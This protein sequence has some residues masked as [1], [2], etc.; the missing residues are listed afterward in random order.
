[1]NIFISSKIMNIFMLLILLAAML[2]LASCGSGTASP[3]NEPHTSGNNDHLLEGDPEDF[4]KI[5][6]ASGAKVKKTTLSGESI[7][8]YSN[9][10]QGYVMM[11]NNGSQRGLKGYIKTPG[12]IFY[13]YNLKADDA[14]IVCPLQAGNGKY[15]IQIMEQTVG[16]FYRPIAKVNVKVTLDDEMLPFLYPN[17]KV[18]FSA[19]SDCVAKAEELTAGLPTDLEK[20]KAIYDYV[21]K[22]IKYD[23]QKAEEVQPGYTPDPDRTLKEGKGICSDYSALLAAMLRSQNIPAKMIEGDVSPGDIRHAWNLVYTKEAG[24]IAMKIAFNGTW[25]MIDPTLDAKLG[26][27]M[28]EYIGDGIVYKED[29]C[30]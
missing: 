3:P 14:F 27:G 28:E 17:Y 8:D 1:M 29:L 26:Y 16:N 6:A 25:E 20:I 4:I 21:V 30:F 24:I 7:I 2:L 23:D 10:A 19:H 22:N 18:N 11:K 15:S 12:G 5:P 9:I 13:Q